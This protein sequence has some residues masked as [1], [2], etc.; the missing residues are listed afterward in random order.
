MQLIGR[1]EIVLHRV[2]QTNNFRPF[3]TRHGAQRF[4]LHIFRQTGGK[5]VDIHLGIVKAFRLQKNLMAWLIC[6]ANNLVFNGRTIAGTAR[7][8]DA[9]VQRRP[10]EP[11]P[12]VFVGFRA[13]VRNPAAQLGPLNFFRL[14]RKWHRRII[15]HLLFQAGIV[16]AIAMNPRRGAGFQAT[17]LKPQGH[18]VL[19][20]PLYGFFAGAPTFKITET[21]VN[22]PV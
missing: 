6:K 7:F 19:R 10:G 11:I 20:E 2:A 1:K 13:G 18:Q 14:K 12:Q 16:D 4:Y 5:P 3:Q 9:G 22:A 15:R 17:R 21:N 8:N